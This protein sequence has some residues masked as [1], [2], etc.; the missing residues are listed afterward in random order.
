MAVST[1]LSAEMRISLVARYC[2][3]TS[4]AFCSPSGSL[5]SP[6]SWRTASSVVDEAQRLICAGI[7]G[8]EA[9]GE[10]I[11]RGRLLEAM[12][13][14]FKVTLAGIVQGAVVAVRDVGEADAEGGEH[15]RHARNDDLLDAH[16]LRNAACRHGAGATEGEQGRLFRLLGEHF[17]RLDDA[18]DVGLLRPPRNASVGSTP[19]GLATFSVM[20][21]RALVGSTWVAAEIGFRIE[22]TEQQVGIGHGGF[23]AAI[24][25]TG[26]A[27]GTAHAVRSTSIFLAFCRDE[28]P[29]TPRLS[30]SHWGRRSCISSAPC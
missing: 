8:A 16:A 19:S 2:R 27:G 21:T 9:L 11:A 12:Q 3:R 18:G 25:E 26:R 6:L 1:A 13:Q 29:P 28:L 10:H 7:E 17:H 24:A 20:A 23:G 22:Q 4:L 14:L 30:T 5:D 15:R